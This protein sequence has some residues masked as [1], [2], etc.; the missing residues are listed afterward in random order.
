[1]LGYLNRPDATKDSITEDGWFKTGDIGFEKDR[2]FKITDRLKE[3]IKFKGQYG[4]ILRCVNILTCK[5]RLPSPS[6]RTRSAP[7]D[8]SRHL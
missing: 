8:A 1:M 5:G 6:G 7:V 4:S 3:L 2:V